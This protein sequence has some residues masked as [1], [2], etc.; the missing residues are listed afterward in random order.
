MPQ[1]GPSGVLAGL[2]RT[3][4]VFALDLILEKASGARVCRWLSALLR[5]SLCGE[6]CPVCKALCARRKQKKKIY[7]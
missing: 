2:L 6:P 7:K 4:V 1:G 3:F 5:E